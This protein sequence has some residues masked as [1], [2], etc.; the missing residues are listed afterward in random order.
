SDASVGRNDERT[1]PGTAPGGRYR[2]ARYR[3]N[4]CAGTGA[5]PQCRTRRMFH[6][7]RRVPTTTSAAL[8]SG[9][10]AKPSQLLLQ[11]PEAPTEG[12]RIAEKEQPD[13]RKRDEHVPVR[14]HRTGAGVR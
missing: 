4:R 9:G 6:H 1:V 10:A 11:L 2:R 14:T 3:R 8:P 13:H 5:R 7:T 12:E